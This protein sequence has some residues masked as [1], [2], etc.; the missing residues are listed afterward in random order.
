MQGPKIVTRKYGMMKNAWR[1]W[2]AGATL[3]ILLTVLAYLPALNGKFVWDDDSWT[4]GIS[5]LLNDISGLRLMWFEPTALQQY[6]PLTGTTFW[7]D[8]QLWV[9]RTLPYHVE[10]VLLH[11]AAALLFWRLLRRLQVPGAWLAGAIFALHP[12]CVE[13]VAWITERKNVLSLILYL[14]ALLAYGRFTRFWEK[15]NGLAAATGVAQPRG[16]MAYV[17]ASW[18]A[19]TRHIGRQVV[20]LPAAI[21]LQPGF[22]LLNQLRLSAGGCQHNGLLCRGNGVIESASGCVSNGQ[23]VKTV[24]VA[25]TCQLASTLCQGHSANRVATLRWRERPQQ[26]GQIVLSD[27]VI[28]GVIQCVSPQ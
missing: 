9:F 13:S 3:I 22:H 27:T 19:L 8:Y 23:G 21:Q 20:S 14:G 2:G 7:L 4:T 26:P 6:Y 1:T 10:N 12:V 28:R 25:V 15:K 11:A 24:C 5:G 18:V 17:F 16:W